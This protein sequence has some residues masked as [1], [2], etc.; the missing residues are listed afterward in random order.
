MRRLNQKKA[1]SVVK[2]FDAFPKIPEG[3]VQTST[4]GGT[5]SLLA[6]SLIIILS[7]MEFLNYRETSIRYDYEVDLDISS[8]L[9]INVDMTIAMK[10][11]HVG[12]DVLDMAETM[13]TSSNG[14]K[15]EP[16]YFE[17]SP[18]QR[19]WYNIFHHIRMR[20]Q[21]EHSLQDV[22]FKTAFNGS[23]TAIPPR[24]EPMEG[25][26]DA[27]RIH[28]SLLVNKVAG[29]F[30]VTIGKAIL[31]PR[32]HAH[33]AAMVEHN[34]YNFSHRIDHFSFGEPVVGIV[35]ALDG[36]EK[37]ANAHAQMFQYFL[38]IV[39][40]QI[41]T[42][43]F[44]ANTHQYSVTEKERTID[45]SAGSHGVSGIFIKYDLNSL[46][47]TVT[48]EGMPFGQF[49][50]GLCGIIGGIFSTTGLLHGLVGFIF[51]FLLCRFKTG[52]HQNAQAEQ[53]IGNS[54]SNN[55]KL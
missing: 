24:E 13:V 46:M 4:S 53:R 29:N 47:V 26:F 32:G 44:S 45:H 7:F 52:V 25:P 38:T 15:Y 43:K 11:Q 23:P 5:V 31:H 1:L 21:Q 10:C 9:Q 51:D 20:L 55:G 41:K 42:R 40:T 30:H 37:I 49:L 18:I 22:L 50:V 28:G 48:E 8:K 6:F 35:N 17:L 39:P 3:C 16:V 14:L 12:A 19:T 34:A 27:C 36:T 33:L 54:L 2:E